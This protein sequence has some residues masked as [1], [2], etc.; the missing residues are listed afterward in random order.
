MNYHTARRD[1]DKPND[2]ESSKIR[3]D[4]IKVQ[5]INYPEKMIFPCKKYYD[6]A[7]ET[8]EGII[9]GEAALTKRKREMLQLKF[10]EENEDLFEEPEVAQDKEDTLVCPP[11]EE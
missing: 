2:D 10:E 4:T 8:M 11:C 7:S 9:E 3:I 1:T 5:A 6:K